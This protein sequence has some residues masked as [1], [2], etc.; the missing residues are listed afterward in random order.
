MG[1]EKE[2]KEM[3][4]GVGY[5]KSK[6]RSCWVYFLGLLAFLSFIILCGLAGYHFGHEYF[7]HNQN[8][9]KQYPIDNGGLTIDDMVFPDPEPE[10]G[11]YYVGMG[12][13]DVTGPIAEVNMMGYAVPSQIAHGLHMRLHSRAFIFADLEKKNRAVF[14]SIDSGMG[15]QIIKLEVI[16]RLKA[17]YGDIYNEKNVVMSG[18]HSH[19]GPAGFFQFL[20]FEVTS[21]GFIKQST[22]SFIDG[23]VKSIEMAHDN[24]QKANL[25]I[26]SGDVDDANINR[27]PSAYTHNP[28]EERAKYQHN[29]EHEM[30]LLKIESPSGAEIGLVTWFPVHG[31]CMNNTNELISSDNK[32]RASTLYETSMIKEGKADFVAAFA[33]ANLGDVSPNTAGP[34]CIDTGKPCD[35]EQSTCNFPPRVKYCIA[36]GPGK[37]GD[38]FQSTD[39][40]GTRQFDAAKRILSEPGS[41]RIQGPVSFA[42]Q[43]VDMTKEEVTLS[44]G[45]KATTCKPGMGYSFAAGTTDGPGAMNFK[46]SMTHGTP[47]WTLATKLIGKIVCKTEPPQSYF[48][49][50]KPKPVLLPTGY[51]DIPYAWHPSVVDVQLL[52]VGQLVIAAVPGEFTTMAGRRLKDAVKAKAIEQGMPS[53]TRI[54]IAGLSNVY[55]HYIATLEEFGAQRYEGASTIFGPHS[56]AAYV[57]RFSNLV[58]NLVNGTTADPGP[59]PQN[60]MAKQIELLPKPRPDRLPAG[61]KYGDLIIDAEESYKTGSNVMVK[62][63]GSNPRHN[64]KLGKTYLEVQRLDSTAGK[65]ETSFTDGD[66]ETKFR[67]ERLSNTN[68]SREELTVIDGIFNLIA[69]ITG[70]HINLNRMEA[71][72]NNGEFSESDLEPNDNTLRGFEAARSHL[73]KKLVTKGILSP[74]E[75]KLKAGYPDTDESHVTIEWDVPSNQQEGTY[76]I[77][78]LG[79]HLA[80]S[81]NITS[82]Q[83]M[84]SEFQVR[85]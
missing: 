73:I 44:D 32:G 21:L 5:K 54:V 62:F 30:T 41:E 23:V 53:D 55:T 81:G 33:Q 11:D 31:T 27:S 3:L 1:N 42:H 82:F 17:K 47:L 66:W 28:E 14:V 22:D 56:H 40:I 59:S 64:M 72:M 16:K 12:R 50:H 70:Y 10:P 85:K 76:R 58:G 45:T 68:V 63:Y 60:I 69:A 74:A 46:Q 48:D 9:H 35:Y 77:L 57:H 75:N 83:G 2:D 52:R 6:K 25:V 34:K 4:L 26:T 19:S 15:S 51:M 29:T 79:D 67:W 13:F 7:F 20:L 61:K 49:C 36:F 71:L 80:E 18:T 8:S 65:W 38:M 39:I 43:Y 24:M 37:N 84:T 78:Y